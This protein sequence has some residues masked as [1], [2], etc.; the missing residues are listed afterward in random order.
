MPV[1]KK[2][3]PKAAG[4][5]AVKKKPA[6]TGGAKKLS[7]P[8]ASGSVV[9]IKV[10]LPSELSIPSTNL[11]EYTWLIHG[12]PK[13]GKTS[14]IAEFEKV[15]FAMFEPGGKALKIFQTP[16][17]KEWA[18]MLGVVNE[19]EKQA[20]EGTL[21]FSSVC[22]DT[23]SKAYDR[24]LEWTCL[25]DHIQ[26]PGKVEDYGA[27]WK[28]VTKAFTDVHTR[29]AALDLGFFVTAHS[30]ATERQ[31]RTGSKE[32]K[33]EP[34]FGGST[35]EFYRGII[36]I[37]AYYHTIGEERFLQIRGDDTVVAGCRLQDNFLTP[38]GDQIKMIPMGNSPKEG[39]SNIIKAYRNRQSKTYSSRTVTVPFKRRTVK[40]KIN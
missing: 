17:I 33:I 21:Q 27:S 7:T 6:Q 3:P 10:T 28:E 31:R 12:E 16:T 30:R 39:H 19:L 37:I 5:G 25:R 40:E 2:A 34:M 24:C 32:L 18:Y 15:L 4:G 13:I 14:L 11:A 8:A 1:K 20:E 36:D 9:P 26:H 35:D 38:N 22:I 29:L 23:G